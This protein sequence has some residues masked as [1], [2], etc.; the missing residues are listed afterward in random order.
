[1]TNEEEELFQAFKN[2]SN[3]IKSMLIQNT[4]KI[5]TKRTNTDF[6]EAR[7][8][9]NGDNL[10]FLFRFVWEESGLN[11]SI[12]YKYAYKHDNEKYNK[13]LDCEIKSYYY[14]GQ[15]NINNKITQKIKNK[16][17]FP[18]DFS[19]FNEEINNEIKKQIKAQVT[20]F[21]NYKKSYNDFYKNWK[22]PD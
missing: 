17:N 22:N 1:M 20:W 18:Q 3:E 13:I 21:E 9:Y 7:K 10:F 15:N 4:E 19:K 12:Y 14:K 6:E 5:K 16:I 11:I 2:N 8:W